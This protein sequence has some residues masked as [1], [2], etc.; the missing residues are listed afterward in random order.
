MSNTVLQVCHNISLTSLVTLLQFWLYNYNFGY[1]I[2]ILVT[3][4]QFWCA[5]CAIL[6]GATNFIKKSSHALHFYNSI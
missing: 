2:T 5:V 1:T 4:L 3:Q 6:C